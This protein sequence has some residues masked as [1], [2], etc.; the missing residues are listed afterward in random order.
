VRPEGNTGIIIK[1]DQ[2]SMHSKVDSTAADQTA[3]SY[4]TNKRKFRWILNMNKIKNFISRQNFSAE[5]N[6]SVKDF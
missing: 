4:C 1:T 5:E 3:P 6:R 2:K